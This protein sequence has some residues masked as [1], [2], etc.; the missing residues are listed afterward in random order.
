[1]MDSKIRL[2]MIVSGLRNE[3]SRDGIV[4]VEHIRLVGTEIET[5]Y[6]VNFNHGIKIYE[7]YICGDVIELL[8]CKDGDFKTKLTTFLS[9]YRENLRSHIKATVERKV[10]IWW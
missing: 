7:G 2:K 9:E 10:G 6:K 8:T 4:K 1:M 5:T 3:L